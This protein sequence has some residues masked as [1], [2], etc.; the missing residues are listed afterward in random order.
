MIVIAGI[1]TI[2]M[3][4]PTFYRLPETNYGEVLEHN[5]EIVILP[6]GAIEPHNYHL[7]YLTD[8]ILTYE[9]AIDCAAMALKQDV[10]CMVMPPVWLGSQNPGQWNKPFCIHTRSETQLAILTDIVTSLYGQG[11]RKMVILN[12][13]GGNSFKPFVRDLAM[14]YPDFT[15]IVVDW[16][17]TVP[18]AGYFEEH[19]DEHAGEQESSVMLHYHP[20]L[21]DLAKAGD[22]KLSPSRIAGVD[23]KAGWMPRNWDEVSADT[24]I[25][26]PSKSTAEKGKRY[27]QAVVQK[28]TSLL[29]DLKRV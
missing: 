20:E 29:V 19:P 22:G 26:N 2:H 25:G 28:I 10:T 1:T 9:I 12:G 4:Y 14:R 21:V 11:F 3:S 16:W 5:Y 15:L 6:W 13:H 24:G 18:T 23:N 27:V 8:A 7:P 17:T